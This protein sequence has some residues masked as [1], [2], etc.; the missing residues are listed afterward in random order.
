MLAEKII[1]NVL[2]FSLFVILFFKMIRRND[3]NYVAILCMQ[4]LRNCH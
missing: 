3:V 2:A 4:A 1:F